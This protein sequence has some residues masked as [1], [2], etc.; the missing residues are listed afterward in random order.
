MGLRLQ[1]R[2]PD[3]GGI[4]V[5][6]L[7]A[8]VEVFAARMARAPPRPALPGAERVEP[9]PTSFAPLLLAYG[10][11][12]HGGAAAGLT[13]HFNGT[14]L[15]D[16]LTIAG[17][18]PRPSW[19]FAI[20]GRSGHGEADLWV[21]GLRVRTGARAR[22]QPVPLSLARNG[23]DF[24]GAAPDFLY[25]G[26]PTIS[27]LTP[28]SGPTAGGGFFFGAGAGGGSFWFFSPA[29]SSNSEAGGSASR[30]FPV[31]ADKAAGASAS[32]RAERFRES[33]PCGASSPAGADMGGV[34]AGSRDLSGKGGT[35]TDAAGKARELGFRGGCRVAGSR[36][37][38]LS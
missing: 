19:R 28:S 13:L 27:S 3:A 16:G 6:V 20:G 25:Y 12:A 1:L 18:A 33:G 22:A 17:W 30:S 21:R 29:A 10:V 2:T 32:G 38:Q 36:Q 34:S 26:V 7:Y 15:V 14:V 31:G 4:D 23:Q 11:S 37:R 8:G 35:V 24:V 9:N 5:R